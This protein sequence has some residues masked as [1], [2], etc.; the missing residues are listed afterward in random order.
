MK[1]AIY[2][3]LSI[4]I[5]LPLT[6][7]SQIIIK[8]DVANIPAKQ[9]YLIDAYS[10]E[11]IDSSI[12]KD[13]KFQFFFNNKNGEIEPKEVSIVYLNKRLQVFAF[14]NPF[15]KIRPTSFMLEDGLTTIKG[16]ITKVKYNTTNPVDISS[17]G[18]TNAFFK[19]F[20]MDFRIK[21][22][23]PIVRKKML[24]NYCS[25]IKLYPDSYYLL[26]QIY[27]NRQTFN[28][29]EL[30]TLADA[31][32]LRLRSSK[33]GSQL[34]QSIKSMSSGTN[35]NKL[36]CKTPTGKMIDVLNDKSKPIILIFWASW[37]VPCRSEIPYLKNMFSKYSG[38][39]Q[40]ASISMDSNNQAWQ[41]A[42]G[43]EKMGWAQFI[44]N[45][46]RDNLKDNFRFSYIPLILIVSNKKI[47]KRFDGFSKE[48]FAHMENFL[49]SI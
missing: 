36:I 10:H 2:S 24:V 34:F 21:S 40:F 30:L 20:L 29:N 12:Y 3:I 17:G 37:C 5:C 26:N 1:K 9:I 43:Q 4:C 42:M 48:E 45:N 11:K 41:M 15:S 27:N 35:L 18:Q 19:T 14:N 22:E 33:Y 28:A 8:G 7:H 47:I 39:I 46:D 38:K 25:T 13:N 6:V 32:D 16:M 49:N 31:F 23:N 44:N